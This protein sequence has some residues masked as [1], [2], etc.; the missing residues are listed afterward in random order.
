MATQMLTDRLTETV[1]AVRGALEEATETPTN[2]YR[3]TTRMGEGLRSET[4]AGSHTVT[5][6]QTA[7]LG[8]DAGPSPVELV[9]AG[10]GSCQEIVYAVHARLLGIPLDSVTVAVEADLDPRGF[11]GAA[12]VPVGFRKVSYTADIR[13]S[14]SPEQ[15]ARLVETVDALCP[16][17][18]ILRDPVP[19]QGGYTLN[20]QAPGA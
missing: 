1:R 2:V 20:G 10:L 12:Q 3:T 13:S 11:F 16:V 14:A 8:G 5:A 7:P 9:L 15:I 19:V 6:D 18:A 4:E 17:T